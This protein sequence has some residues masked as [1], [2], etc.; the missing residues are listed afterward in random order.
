[1]TKPITA[2]LK[3][4]KQ[5][6]ANRK[7]QH[8]TYCFMQL[9]TAIFDMDGLLIDSEPLWNEAAAEV[10]KMYGVSLSEEQY[11]STTGLR[12]KEFVQWWF[13]KFNLGDAEHAR[14]ERLILERVM[15]KI[16][17]KG[18][19]MPGVQYIFRFFYE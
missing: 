4:S 2:S 18:K 16:E 10:F 19:I 5:Y 12:T 11:H 1:M 7:L 14:A 8:N 13:Q 9:N 15:A 3:A 6:T 17:A